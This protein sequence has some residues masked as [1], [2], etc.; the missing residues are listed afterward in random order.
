MEIRN[1]AKRLQPF[2]LKDI[3]REN[4]AHGR[5]SLPFFSGINGH[6]RYCTRLLGGR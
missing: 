6:F 3:F 1:D 4:D 5:P 2:K